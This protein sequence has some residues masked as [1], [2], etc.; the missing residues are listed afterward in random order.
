MGSRLHSALPTYFLLQ[1]I[2]L[3]VNNDCSG[4]RV[5]L[6]TELVAI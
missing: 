3:N 5:V 1:M 6:L 2:V 4:E